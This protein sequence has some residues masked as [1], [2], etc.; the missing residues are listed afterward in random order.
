MLPSICNLLLHKVPRNQTT[1]SASNSK[2]TVEKDPSP[3]ILPNLKSCGRFFRGCCVCCC[4]VFCS[5]SELGLKS[6]VFDSLVEPAWLLQ[7][8]RVAGELESG[9]ITNEGDGQEHMTTLD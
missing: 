2:L 6:V 7:V 5:V 3:R 8:A 1:P 9:L 4:P